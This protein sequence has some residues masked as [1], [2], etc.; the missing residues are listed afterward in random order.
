MD[1]ANGLVGQYDA[2][3]LTLTI[4]KPTSHGTR[5]ARCWRCQLSNPVRRCHLLASLV[6]TQPPFLEAHFN[7]MS[8]ELSLD[9]YM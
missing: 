2:L 6:Y 7:P 9:C 8:F 3:E 1:H 5:G 4:Q